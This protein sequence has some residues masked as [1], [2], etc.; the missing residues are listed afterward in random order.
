MPVEPSLSHAE[1]VHH[2]AN[3][4]GMKAMFA[5]RLRGRLK[6]LFVGFGLVALFHNSESAHGIPKVLGS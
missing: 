4:L 1:V 3:F 5:K 2:M 6:D